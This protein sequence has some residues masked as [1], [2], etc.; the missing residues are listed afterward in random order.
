MGETTARII[1]TATDP[2]TAFVA[3]AADFCR[4]RCSTRK[5][6][7]MNVDS[8]WLVDRKNPSYTQ[9][10]IT[11]M[12]Q[13]P[14]QSTDRNCKSLGGFIFA[15]SGDQMVFAQLDYDARWPGSEVPSVSLDEGTIVPRKLR[16]VATPTKFIYLK[17]M[18]RTLAVATTELK[19]LSAP[20]K[21]CRAVHSSLRLLSIYD[22]QAVG[23]A[24]VKQEVG[25]PT[26]TKASINGVFPLKNSERVYSMVEWI[27]RN[28]R[29]HPY[30]FIILGTG[31]MDS[32]G[33]E[34]GRRLVLKV[35]K[36]EIK[37]KQEKAYRHPVRCIAFWDN[38]HIISIIGKTLSMQNYDPNQMK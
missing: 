11:A 10:P 24:E 17:G 28:D 30:H 18:R 5:S 32:S 8:L 15:V 9:G 14:F 29:A 23:E 16:T 36:S 3:C 27:Y 7:A 2:A 31:Y 13:L 6:S 12:D 4:I 38:T 37:L 20:P 21:G 34:V 35:T 33:E 25:V 1:P 26:P 19:E 22:D